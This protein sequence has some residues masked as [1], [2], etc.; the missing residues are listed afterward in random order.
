MARIDALA[1]RQ[2]D[3]LIIGAGIYGA[4][5][6]YYAASAGL[7]VAL[8]DKGDYG[9]GASANSLKILHGGLRYLQSL[10]LIR[11]RQSIRA[12]RDAFINLPHLTRPATFVVPVGTS[13]TRS[14]AAYRVATGLNDVISFDRNRGVPASHY[15]PRG[16]VWSRNKLAHECPALK[17]YG[18][19]LVWSDGMIENTERYTLAYVLGAAGLG[20]VTMNYVKA[21]GLLRSGERIIGARVKDV[22]EAD[23]GEVK[24]AL[25]I[26][27]AG[28]WMDELCPEKT[29]RPGPR[30]WLRA[31]NIIA[32]KQ[33]FGPYGV[34]LD[35]PV[36]VAATGEIKRRN[37]F[38]APWRGHTMI[39]TV[40]DPVDPARDQVGLASS[41]LERFTGE[42]NQLFPAAELC[43]DDITYA[44]VGIQPAHEKSSGVFTAEPANRMSFIDRRQ[45]GYLAVQGVKFTTAAVHMR[46]L[47]L[48]LLDHLGKPGQPDQ[49]ENLY[50]TPLPD[51]TP[52]DLLVKQAVE[53]EQARHLDDI[54]LR[55]TGIGS[56]GRPDSSVIERIG[57]YGAEKMGW[58]NNKASKE[59]HRCMLTALG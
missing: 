43:P 45:L 47:T 17:N 4:T 46:E 9:S 26:N 28:L 48:S 55:R 18:G 31:W 24:A 44:H 33:W 15:T 5:L 13:L 32:K 50:R 49:G 36:K 3:L 58:D 34:G 40:Y 25:T 27:T 57:S 20:A 12:R 52:L 7:S 2:F 16:T 1:D 6:A 21:T 22:D 59:K 8:I 41:D 42:I 23:E 19:A 14:A 35:G 51:D 39:G 37:F 56:A 38:F 54:L 11:M 29:M 30:G 10:D 53:H